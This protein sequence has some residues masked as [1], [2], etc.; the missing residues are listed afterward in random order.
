MLTAAPGSYLLC[1]ALSAC[2]LCRGPKQHRSIPSSGHHALSYH[3][4]FLLLYTTAF[5]HNQ[6]P[7]LLGLPLDKEQE[8]VL[9][10]LLPTHMHPIM[11]EIRTWGNTHE[12]GLICGND[13]AYSGLAP[14]HWSSPHRPTAIPLASNHFPR[15][16][17]EPTAPEPLNA[18]KTCME[19]PLVS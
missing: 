3:L 5:P 19:H 1:G 17:L 16:L 2:D 11:T 6:F 8:L 18:L 14:E 7:K 10:S 13:N 4:E 9:Q 12:N 15:C